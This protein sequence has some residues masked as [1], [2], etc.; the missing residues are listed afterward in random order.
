MSLRRLL[1]SVSFL[2]TYFLL[3]VTLQNRVHVSSGEHAAVA[4]ADKEN[5]LSFSGAGWDVVQLFAHFPPPPHAA[6]CLWCLFIFPIASRKQVCLC[7]TQTRLRSVTVGEGG[8]RNPTRDGGGGRERRS[9]VGH[10]TCH[11][12]IHLREASGEGRDAHGRHG[13]VKMP[14]RLMWSR[15]TKLGEENKCR[16]RANL[17]NWSRDLYTCTLKPFPTFNCKRVLADRQVTDWHL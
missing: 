10:V 5:N 16:I 2:F 14:G 3:F 4:R 1:C 15:D 7:A 17:Q 6:S 9:E 12:E 13:C 11:S 8:E